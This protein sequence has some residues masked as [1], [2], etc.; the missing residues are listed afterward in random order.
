MLTTG[1]TGEPLIQNILLLTWNKLSS[2]NCDIKHHLGISQLIIIKENLSNIFLFSRRGASRRPDPIPGRR[3]V[4]WHHGRQGRP[5]LGHGGKEK[6]HHQRHNGRQNKGLWEERPA[7]N[8]GFHWK[9]QHRSV[10]A[11]RQCWVS[12]HDWLVQGG[13]GL[14]VCCPARWPHRCWGNIRSSPVN[15]LQHCQLQGPVRALLCERRYKCGKCKRQLNVEGKVG[16][17]F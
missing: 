10:S 16:Q 2:C 5:R 3:S 7:Y 17:S 4:A 13:G 14:S 1:C 12:L 11:P 8:S 15:I 6:L 9:R